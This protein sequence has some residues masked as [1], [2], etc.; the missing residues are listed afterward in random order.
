MDVV[1]YITVG[2][3]VIKYMLFLGGEIHNVFMK[4][5]FVNYIEYCR[6]LNTNSLPTIF[7]IAPLQ[8]SARFAT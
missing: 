7:V 1:F 5:P 3:L 8:L 6:D 4:F 2:L